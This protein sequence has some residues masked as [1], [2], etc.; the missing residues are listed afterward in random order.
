[1]RYVT[2]S[3]TGNTIGS[4]V[5]RRKHLRNRLRRFV[6]VIL[7][8]VTVCVQIFVVGCYTILTIFD[9]SW[10]TVNPFALSYAVRTKLNLTDIYESAETAFR[11]VGELSCFVEGVDETDGSPTTVGGCPCKADWFGRACSIP[12]FISRSWTPWSK[13]TLQ[14]LRRG[15]M[16]NYC[17]QF[18]RGAKIIA[19]LFQMWFYVQLLHAS[20][21]SNAFK[22]V[23]KCAIIATCCMI[24]K[25][26]H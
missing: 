26:R 25:P 6:F 7:P 13:E 17:A 16:R 4:H 10:P 5:V 9:V 12:G 8:T 3:Q 19:R 22:R 2:P 11:T 14:V 15:F 24:M 21:C 18:L 20:S 1:M 23:G